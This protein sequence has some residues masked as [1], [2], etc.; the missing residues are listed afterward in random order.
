[1]YFYDHFSSERLSK[2]KCEASPTQIDCSRRQEVSSSYAKG[3]RQST[4][5]TKGTKAESAD[6]GI[7]AAPQPHTVGDARMVSGIRRNALNTSEN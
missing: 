1:M 4:H 3:D 2:A 5:I 6:C 7:C